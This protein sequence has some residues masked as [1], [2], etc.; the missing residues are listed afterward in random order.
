[1]GSGPR[2]LGQLA[3]SD[4]I[5][6]MAFPSN[7]NSSGKSKKELKSECQKYGLALGGNKPE[8][9]A[10]LS[11]HLISLKSAGAAAAIAGAP[12]ERVVM[13]AGGEGDAGS[14]FA[15]S[16]AFQYGVTGFM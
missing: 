15:M 12:V 8:L 6:A 10:R 9:L 5:D 16:H 13:G 1:M 4:A 2:E 7:R 3:S 14:L 11:A